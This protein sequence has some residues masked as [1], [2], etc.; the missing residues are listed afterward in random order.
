MPA[1]RRTWER[2]SACV[3]ASVCAHHR[4][5]HVSQC[6]LL[7][8]MGNALANCCG[9]NGGVDTGKGQG[10]RYIAGQAPTAI[11]TE[12]AVQ[13]P[14]SPEERR[15]KLAAAAL[16]RE[17]KNAVRGTQRETYVNSVLQVEA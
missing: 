16:E 5:V 14:S 15:E 10:P 9:D 13:A 12:N 6:T 11:A 4:P 8:S 7:K 3:S 2:S 1:S 17:R